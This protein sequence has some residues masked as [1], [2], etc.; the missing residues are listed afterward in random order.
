[1][2]LEKAFLDRGEAIRLPAIKAPEVPRKALLLRFAFMVYL[3]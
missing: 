3:F 2:P 1:L